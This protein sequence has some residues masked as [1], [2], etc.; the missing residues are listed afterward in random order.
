MVKAL[1]SIWVWNEQIQVRVPILAS[2]GR[3]FETSLAFRRY[4]SYCLAS[5]KRGQ[6]TK[7]AKILWKKVQA[8]EGWNT[9][10]L[11]CIFSAFFLIGNKALMLSPCQPVRLS[12]CKP[13]FSLTIKHTELIFSASLRLYCPGTSP[14]FVRFW[15]LSSEL[16]GQNHVY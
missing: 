8:L 2:F 10:V 7:F 4:R 1:T 16:H 5:L 13:I 9:V 11:Y 6:P 14:K 15:Q 12:V 3:N